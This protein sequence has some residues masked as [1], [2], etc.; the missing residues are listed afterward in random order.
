[1]TVH[2]LR[3]TCVAALALATSACQPPQTATACPE[4]L[5]GGK[6]TDEAWLGMVDARARP[7]DTSGSVLLVSPAEGQTY[8]ANAPPPT[9]TWAIPE[10][11]RLAPAIPAA[12]PAPRG[13]SALAW[14]GELLLPSA[15]AHLPP[16][17]GELYWVEVS[18]P[19][20]QCPVAQMLT[21]EL[22]WPL[23]TASWAK[24][25][26][27]AGESLQVQVTRAYLVQNAVTEGPYR[28]EPPRVIR[29]SAP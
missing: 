24:L 17:T 22:S 18:T 3:L 2:P 25:G 20:A 1:M 9:W 8:A 19:G 15:H 23:D 4:P 10:A 13:R 7:L 21:S 6:A 12:A 28:L 26:E 5:Y 16:Y 27:H 11:S 14:L 29:R